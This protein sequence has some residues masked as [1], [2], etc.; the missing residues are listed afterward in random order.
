MSSKTILRSAIDKLRENTPEKRQALLP[1][2]IFLFLIIGITILLSSLVSDKQI[3][4]DSFAYVTI[5]II[6]IIII[7]FFTASSRIETSGIKLFGYGFAIL[8]TIIFMVHYY[9]TVKNLSPTYVFYLSLL[10]QILVFAIIIVGM[11]IFY[12]V[13]SNKLMKMPGAIGTA[14]NILFFLPC[15]LNDFILYVKG[16][17][18]NTPSVT[19]VLL[20]IEALLITLYVYIPSILKRDLTDDNQLLSDPIFLKDEQIIAYGEDLP[21]NIFDYTYEVASP[22]LNYSIS[23]WVYLNVQQLSEIP[24]RIF[25]YSD[26]KL[27]VE[28][29]SI[30]D[31]SDSLSIESLDKND[32]LKIT[33]LKDN[34]GNEIVTYVNTPKQ[35]WNYIVV[36][37]EDNYAT[38]FM[39]GEML[40]TKNYAAVFPT[41]NDNDQITVGDNDLDGA[42]CN[43]SYY[44]KVLTKSEIVTYYN[45]LINQNPPLNNIL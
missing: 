17:F 3:S 13:F 34:S 14:V 1:N 5:F 35:K 6:P 20:V 31:N 12:N 16:Q 42:I 37:Y 44:D 4:Y 43:V 26:D 11:S 41:Y 33:F 19:Y 32:K 28:Y 36:N 40:V 38:L 45:L 8:I 25:S 9:G 2:I 21:K 10:T 30:F 15:L 23:M 22:N 7:I 29:I 27:R 24:K 18:T 39:N